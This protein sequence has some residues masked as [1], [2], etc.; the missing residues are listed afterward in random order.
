MRSQTE[1]NNIDIVDRSKPILN[2]KV[3]HFGNVDSNRL[4]TATGNSVLQCMRSSLPIHSD[5]I[6]IPFCFDQIS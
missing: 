3:N 5:Q 2:Q 6:D 1:S 4:N